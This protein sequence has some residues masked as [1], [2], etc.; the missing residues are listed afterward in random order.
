MVFS[1]RYFLL[2]LMLARLTFRVHK[3][4]HRKSELC[5][6]V[7]PQIVASCRG[8]FGQLGHYFHP[9]SLLAHL[10]PVARQNSTLQTGKWCSSRRPSGLRK[11]TLPFNSLAHSKSGRTPGMIHV[12]C[13][14]RRVSEVHVLNHLLSGLQCRIMV[15]YRTNMRQ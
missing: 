6:Y 3:G 7:Y 10:G 2:K 11:T 1:R 4:Q 15:S 12:C 8:R 14:A 9:T 13:T 5:L